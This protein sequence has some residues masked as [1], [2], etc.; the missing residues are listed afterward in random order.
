MEVYRE[1]S[2]L[3]TECS[4]AVLLPAAAQG[5]DAASALEDSGHNMCHWDM[6]KAAALP[7]FTGD[8]GTVK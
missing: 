4:I 3:C 1:H 6:D 8:A 2:T 5:G 7:A